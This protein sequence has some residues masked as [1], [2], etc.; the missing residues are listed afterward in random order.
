V[1]RIREAGRGWV[2]SRPLAGGVAA[3][4]LLLNGVG[5]TGSRLDTR[6]ELEDGLV[7]APCSRL[8]VHRQMLGE[9][10]DDRGSDRRCH[11]HDR[12]VNVCN[13]A[14]LWNQVF[15]LRALQS[16]V[17]PLF[18]G[19]AA[20]RDQA[21]LVAEHQRRWAR[22][23]RPTVRAYVRALSRREDIR[24][25]L[26]LIDVPTLVL[27]GDHDEAE[28][29]A[30]SQEIAN[31]LPKANLEVIP[32]AGHLAPPEQPESVTRLLVASLRQLA[33]DSSMQA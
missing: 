8:A 10:S 22:M 21:E 14:L 7:G 2:G 19:V 32:D 26:P 9:L 1:S 24:G 3:G 29:L 31:G 18:F 27:V 33:A 17:T 13:R 11:V 30:K 5:R 6:I 28:P 20:R 15:G 4:D 25:L 12:F 16:Q 23:D